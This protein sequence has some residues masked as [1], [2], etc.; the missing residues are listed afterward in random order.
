MTTI[1]EAR[2]TLGI[3]DRTLSDFRSDGL[4][5]KEM[6]RL[7]AHV[8]T[9]PACQQRLADYESLAE[10]L[11]RQQE[12]DGHAALWQSVRASIAASEVAS[13]RARRRVRPAH[14]SRRSHS[15]RFWAAFGSIAAVVAL[16]IGFVALFVSRGGWPPTASTT[17]TPRI[18]HSG[19]LTWRQVI[20][21]KGFPDAD[22]ISKE[23]FATN[24]P[25]QI[26]FTDGKTAYACQAD[27]KRISLP[28]VWATHDAGKSWLVI[29]PH[30]LP[31][32]TGGCRIILD[33]NDPRRLIVSLYPVSIPKDVPLPS[34]WV[35]YATFDGGATWTKPA[36]LQQANVTYAQVSA[37][38]KIYAL[39]ASVTA[40]WPANVALYVSGDQMQSW[41][42]ID[43]ALPE[44]LPN[45]PEAQS[46]DKIFQV[47]ANPATGELLA[48]TYVGSLWSTHDDGMHWTQI[49]YPEGIYS[50][51]P[52]VPAIFTGVSTTSAQWPICGL[53][54]SLGSDSEQWLECTT[55]DGKTW[56]KRPSHTDSSLVDLTPLSIGADGSIYALGSDGPP[57]LTF[58]V[59]RLPPDGATAADW[60]RL[61]T[62]PGSENGTGCGAFPSGDE[63]V[64]WAIPG[65]STT[66]DN[67]G[68]QTFTQPYYYVATYP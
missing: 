48:I 38:G 43:E 57:E 56:N 35:T 11:R 62:I 60:Q 29:T 17:P 20:V 45:G 33:A 50:T 9:C 66:S 15:P 6:E 37:G 49:A 67:S 40:N 4:S 30:D 54:M 46:A 32:D 58:A 63:M 34:T 39:R 59:Y 23:R 36:G 26:A 53:F 16:S 65:V 3:T 61:G 19:S 52:H 64:F 5:T 25:A 44:K 55:D 42:R 2:C 13:G 28:V 31:A 27:K 41:T 68:S 10:A 47:W 14:A 1:S 8:E 24:S 22:Q 21:P 18:I 51:D 7:R 12:L